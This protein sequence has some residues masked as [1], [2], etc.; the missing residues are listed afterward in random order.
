[1]SFLTNKN[2][3]KSFD[4]SNFLFNL[5]NNENF[6]E[7]EPFTKGM[8]DFFYQSYPTRLRKPSNL[9]YYN[10]EKSDNL[11][12]EEKKEEFT[13]LSFTR[14]KK[15]S[16]VDKL[17]NKE[18]ELEKQK[19]IIEKNEKNGKK[20]REYKKKNIEKVQRWTAE[21]NQKYE[22]FIFDHENIME[23][24]SL[25]RNAKIF[26]AMSE[27]IASKTPSQCRSHHQKFYKKLCENKQNNDGNCIKKKT[28]I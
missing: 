6:D 19:K 10:T 25:K 3:K 23:N 17:L 20:R 7:K 13:N 22:K 27:F 2:G 18:N 14:N 1:M 28:K 12:T 11:F 9:D 15:N 21:E 5:N 4:I 24:S 16:L 8:D 26:L